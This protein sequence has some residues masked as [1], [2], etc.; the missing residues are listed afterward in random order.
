MNRE[1]L[2]V[3]AI[4]ADKV[5]QLSKQVMLSIAGYAECDEICI[6]WSCHILALK[7]CYVTS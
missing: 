7:I 1:L 2:G 4:D 6:V 3:S 5:F